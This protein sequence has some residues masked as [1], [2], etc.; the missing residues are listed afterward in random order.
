MKPHYRAA[1]YTPIV[2]CGAR[3]PR[4]GFKLLPWGVATADAIAIALRLFSFD[5][6]SFA[7][8]PLR[9]RH[10]LRAWLLG[11]LAVLVVGSLAMALLVTLFLP[12][13]DALAHRTAQALEE[14][15]G[16]PVSI[17]A[18]TW[19]LLPQP[20]VEL[21]DIAISQPPAPAADDDA[22][23]A[24]GKVGGRVAPAA[25]AAAADSSLVSSRTAG[26]IALQRVTVLPALSLASLWQRTVR[27]GQIEVDGGHVPQ[28]TLARLG[29]GRSDIG[30]T[31]TTSSTGDTGSKPEAA[32]LGF[33]LAFTPVDQLVWRGV[34]WKPRHGP[35][36]QLSGDATFD[37]ASQLQTAAVRLLQTTSTTDIILSR[38][39]TGA[40]G[41][42]RWAVKSRIGG[43]TVDGALELSQAGNDWLLSG[44]LTPVNV[45]VASAMEAFNRR[46]VVR[47][48]ASGHTVISARAPQSAGLSALV[49]SLQTN[50][51][52][53]I[54]TSQLTRFDL[55]KAIRSA[56]KDTLGQTP[57]DS[58]A[59]QMTTRNT[60]SGMAT[61]FVD[62]TARAG[63]L[64]AVG[65]ATVANGEV[66]AALAVDLV[67]G[68]VGV[69][70]RIT[71]PFN[72]VKVSVPPS[73]VAGAA[74]GT[75]VLPGVGTAVG[76]RL[77]TALSRLFGADA[78]SPR[79][80][81]V[82]TPQRQMP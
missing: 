40:A 81:K 49:A 69:P 15:L 68:V 58:I 4:T 7:I 33:R 66:D 27:L 50:T 28:R 41:N 55:N 79:P 56:G 19:H 3:Q 5:M 1:S 74:I 59:G 30:N 72:R 6:T 34:V 65:S 82:P 51:R 47:G 8:S 38:T 64:S 62:V 37:A 53:N 22:S 80:A 29:T 20:R 35:S 24:S 45:E 46:S 23:A 60:P 2:T 57:L 26:P 25:A 44:K 76:A 14:A 11:A 52:F 43:G 36:V 39:D 32:L 10:T 48:K 71:G 12:T 9:R 17:G 16:A 75:V 63:A 61:R 70:L 21:L 77:G 42:P 78:P 18:L 54:G 73:A 67:D 13:N 31:G